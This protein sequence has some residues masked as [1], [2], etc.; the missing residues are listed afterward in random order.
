M[1]VSNS[2]RWLLNDCCLYQTDGEGVSRLNIDELAGNLAFH[3]MMLEAHLTP[4]AGL[5]DCVSQG[6]HCDMDINTFIASS[7]ALRPFMKAFVRAGRSHANQPADTLLTVLRPLGVNAEYA[8]SV[9]TDGVNTHKGM[10]F[11]MGII[12]GAVG[13][14]HQNG[15]SFRAAAVQE[16]IKQCCQNLVSDDLLQHNARPQTAGERIFRQFGLT[17]IRGEAACGYPTIF[18]YGLPVYEASIEKG[19]SEEQAM[20]KTLCSLMVHNNDTNLINRGGLEGLLYVQLESRRLLMQE[21][22]S[23][24]EVLPLIVELDQQLINRNL[25]PGGSADLLAATWLLAQLNLCSKES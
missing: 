3:A 9:A 1:I 21:D 18:K 11:T 16:V 2:V 22:F 14:L 7:E 20:N 23:T 6:A 8:M 12:C 25:S 4:K 15:M 17:G 5:V 10:I 13:W 19:Y 24:P